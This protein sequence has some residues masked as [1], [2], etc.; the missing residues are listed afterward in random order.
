MTSLKPHRTM[1]FQMS[2]IYGRIKPF[3]A[4]RVLQ[5]LAHYANNCVRCL[6]NLDSLPNV[7]NM[8]FVNVVSVSI[9]KYRHTCIGFSIVGMRRWNDWMSVID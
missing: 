2:S 4:F 6:K 8:Q 7:R 1:M 5:S 9:C 3:Y